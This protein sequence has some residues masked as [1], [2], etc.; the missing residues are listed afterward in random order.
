MKKVEYACAHVA[1]AIQK[2]LEVVQNGGKFVSAF[3]MAGFI[4]ITVEETERETFK[5]VEVDLVVVDEMSAGEPTTPAA[6]A[7]AKRGKK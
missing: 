1:E 6:K 4:Y 5:G 7:T 3:E 2:S